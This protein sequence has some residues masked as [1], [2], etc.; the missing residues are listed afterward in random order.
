MKKTMKLALLVCLALLA[1]A[2]MFTACDS[3][4]DSQVHVHSYGEWTITKIATCTMDGIKERDCSCGDIQ[5]VPVP[6]TGHSFGTWQITKEVTCTVDGS[7][8]RSCACGEKETRTISASH[9]WTEAD[10]INAKTCKICNKAEG[11]ALGH[12]F[13]N[14]KCNICNTIKIGTITT[15]Q[16]LPL[17][18]DSTVFFETKGSIDAVT[19]SFSDSKLILKID[20]HQIDI[21]I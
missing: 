17:I 10:C 15:T 4:N 5:S 16:E 13:V 18:M 6:A 8:A 7:E 19:Y 9:S 20:Y 3:G 11:E 1:C 2:L 21:E 14:G 12:N